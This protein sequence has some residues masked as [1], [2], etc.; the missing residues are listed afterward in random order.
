[1]HPHRFSTRPASARKHLRFIPP[2]ARGAIPSRQLYL[3]TMCGRMTLT[4]SDLGQVL[5]E[6][7]EALGSAGVWPISADDDAPSLFRPRYN[8]APTQLH[9]VLRQLR[10][11]ANL[12]FAS[13][14]VL[15]RGPGKLP[16]RPAQRAPLPIRPPV[17]KPAAD[18]PRPLRPQRLNLRQLPQPIQIRSRVAR[19]PTD[20][21]E[22]GEDLSG[23]SASLRK[24]PQIRIQSTGLPFTR[25]DGR[26]YHAAL[27]CRCEGDLQA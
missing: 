2:R 26:G 14:G 6:L 16:A 22:A 11:H 18:Q 25:Q 20:I 19:H 3:P 13:W 27:K 4:S 5:G 9:P 17:S 15:A 24:G 7:K 21:V 12:S 1:M 10:D 23:S 8:V